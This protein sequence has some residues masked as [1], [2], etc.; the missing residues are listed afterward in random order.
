[1]NTGETLAFL[2]IAAG[3]VINFILGGFGCACILYFIFNIPLRWGL[4][5][6][7]PYAILT[8]VIPAILLAKYSTIEM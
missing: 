8:I 5:F 6:W 4:L 7:I 2:L 1:M 3:T